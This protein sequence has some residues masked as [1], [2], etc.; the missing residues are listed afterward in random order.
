MSQMP[1]QVSSPGLFSET[2]SFS[3]RNLSDYAQM[4]AQN[5]LAKAQLALERTKMDAM[6]DQFQQ[7]MTQRQSEQATGVAEAEK[8]RQFQMQQVQ[9]G[10]QFQAGQNEL[11]RRMQEQQLKQADEQFYTMRQFEI[12]QINAKSREAMALATTQAEREAIQAAT[13][14]EIELAEARMAAAKLRFESNDRM[15]GEGSAELMGAAANME[16]GR[17]TATA[18]MADSLIKPVQ[19]AVL[20]AAYEARKKKMLPGMRETPEQEASR[21][22]MDQEMGN[23]LVTSRV[24]DAV[25]SSIGNTQGLEAVQEQVRDYIFTALQAADMPDDK[26]AQKNASE[27]LSKLLK[28]GRVDAYQ[29]RE[30]LRATAGAMSFSDGSKT[31]MQI[32]QQVRELNKGLWDTMTDALQITG[33][34]DQFADEFLNNN[35]KNL[36]E[37]A[38][39]LRSASG[40]LFNGKSVIEPGMLTATFAAG[41]TDGNPDNDGPI[42]AQLQQFRGMPGG[43]SFLQA[44]IANTTKINKAAGKLLQAELEIKT[45]GEDIDRVKKSEIDRLANLDERSRKSLSEVLDQNEKNLGRAMGDRGNRKEK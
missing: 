5:D 34:P 24:A 10:Q 36:N 20:L 3:L 18:A 42:I 39:R 43:A 15:K 23:R 45:T 12:E 17:S 19:N 29:A 6:K 27:A 4:R 44:V 14:R 40:S 25:A 21:S 11:D 32:Q 9:Q 13:Q 16:A 8:N 1:S 30:L 41:L 35:V 31:D 2:G 37:R 26:T 7:E 38:G 22:R 28:T 33:T